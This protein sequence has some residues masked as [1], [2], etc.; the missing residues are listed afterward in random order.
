MCVGGVNVNVAD[1][2]F[3]IPDYLCRNAHFFKVQQAFKPNN[4]ASLILIYSV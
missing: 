1:V 3:G 4:V 2:D